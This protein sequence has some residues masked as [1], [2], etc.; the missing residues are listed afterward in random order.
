M[1][2]DEADDFGEFGVPAYVIQKNSRR[3]IRIGL[4]EFNRREYMDVREFYRADS[5]YRPTSRGITLPPSRYAELLRG[6]LELGSELGII[7]PVVI[8]QVFPQ[9]YKSEPA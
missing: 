8:D 7:D 9:E 6:V 5:G 3:Q 1:T 2:S 4:N